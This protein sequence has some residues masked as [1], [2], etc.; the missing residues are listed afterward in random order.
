MR[1]NTVTR[2]FRRSFD[3]DS[4]NELGKATRLCQRRRDFAPFRLMLTLAEALACG[5]LDSIADIR[6]TFT[7]LCG[8]QVEYKPFRNQLRKPGFP[9]FVRLM[10]TRL[11]NDLACQVLQF[12]P[13]SPFA[14]FEH[15]RIQ[16]G[17]SFTRKPALADVF[18]G[19]F[20]TMSP[21]AI[22]LHVDIDLMSE[23]VNQVTLSADSEA[24]RQFLPR[25]EQVAGG[26]LLADRGH[27]STPYLA[28]VDCT[29]GC[30]IVR[31]RSDPEE[32]PRTHEV[33]STLTRT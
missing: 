4:L 7:A 25:P 6:R 17:T 13:D 9:K 2:E 31:G 28:S 32:S 19:R 29:G 16:D 1:A 12:F 22:E 15:I 3:E 21:G 33:S 20:T 18:S 10:L 11:L 26:L 14:R 24:E 27:F 5:S 8:R 23:M 30:F